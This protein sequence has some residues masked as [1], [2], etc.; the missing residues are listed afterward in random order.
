MA[1]PTT[2]LEVTYV[3]NGSTEETYHIGFPFLDV[4]HIHVAVSSDGVEEAVLLSPS[5]YVVTRNA[6]GGG[7]SL[8]T[9]AAISSPATVTIFRE[10]PLTQPTVFQV[11]GPFPAKS[12]ETALDRLLMQVQQINRGLLALGG[13]AGPPV[14]IGAGTGTLTWANAAA[15]AAVLP[16]FAG[17][18]GI[19]RETQTLWI[20]E[21]A[22]VG[23][24]REFRTRRT[25]RLV[26]GYTADAGSQTI[27]QLEVK[28]L[29]QDWDVDAALFGGDNNYSGAGLFDQ[30][31][32]GFNDWIA[33]G[34]A[35]PA[36][37]NHDMDEAGWEARYLA[38]F[39]YLPQ[40]RYYTVTLG[41]GL[42]DLFVLNSGR[43]SVW[44]LTEPDGNSPTSVQHAW[45]V[46]QLAASK[47]RWKIV[48]FHH[49]PASLVDDLSG[50][51]EPEMNWPEFAQVD[52]LLCGHA[53]LTEALKINNVTLWNMSSVERNDGTLGA[54]IQGGSTSD[55]SLWGDDATPCCGRIV[56]TEEKLTV[57]AW[58]LAG[59]YGDA[60]LLTAR[61]VRDFIKAP[62]IVES[63]WSIPSDTDIPE[64]SLSFVTTT[65]APM[66]LREVQISVV[67]GDATEDMTW[68]LYG[69]V[70][71][72]ATGTL[73]AGTTFVSVESD[74]QETMIPAGTVIVVQAVH[75][76]STHS[77][78]EVALTYE[79]HS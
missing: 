79:R 56:A 30:D 57:E 45:F 39:P 31:W 77:G 63:F 73:L 9:A 5:G 36:L 51:I 60:G 40:Q 29:F 11:A 17:Q 52:L 53:H 12:N 28:L 19:E 26:L 47:A 71:A 24:W 44:T 46:E 59:A 68:T 8:K 18:V 75:A 64:T 34:T 49:P 48:M 70:I 33:A 25:N 4:A 41:D 54:T 37:G 61:D 21:T 10:V 6:D 74:V 14:E 15:R 76:V 67:N 55:A 65:A 50:R 20:A 16:I 42:V 22:T 7:G 32:F 43:D 27:K 62:R 38:K 2:Q 35:Y 66:I 13:E 72:L 1:V 23:D 78:L 3:G 69:G 58:G